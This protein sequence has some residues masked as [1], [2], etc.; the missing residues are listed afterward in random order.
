MGKKYENVPTHAPSQHLS[1]IIRV[2]ELQ[3]LVSM[4]SQW[5]P[6]SS[7]QNEILKGLGHHI[8]KEVE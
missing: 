6:V 8:H 2:Q 1:R 5:Q 3:Q 7:I 4:V